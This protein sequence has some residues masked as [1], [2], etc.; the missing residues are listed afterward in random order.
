MLI[1]K[2]SIP[3]QFDF[4][5][6]I[7]KREDANNV[8][9]HNPYK[10][11]FDQINEGNISRFVKYHGVIDGQLKQEFLN[12]A[13][14]LILPTYYKIEGQPICII[15]ALSFGMPVITTDYR[16]IPEQIL[17]K[18]NMFRFV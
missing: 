5:G 17:N 18:I 16:G 2:K 4:C 8:D 6:A 12:N 3:F 1:N 7:I 9:G 11:F 10:S 14:I 15:E 13:D